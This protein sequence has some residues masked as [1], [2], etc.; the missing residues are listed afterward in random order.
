[1]LQSNLKQF[2]LG[3]DGITRQE[4]REE[5]K[6]VNSG[7][8]SREAIFF[9]GVWG[10][11]FCF[12]GGG[13]GFGEHGRQFCA[14][15]NSLFSPNNKKNLLLCHYSRIKFACGFL[16]FF[17]SVNQSDKLRSGTY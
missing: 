3:T 6:S 11:F 16:L 10:G 5:E 12:F 4:S 8:F 14:D 1:M 7:H 15:T 9:F 13:V 2:C 17:S